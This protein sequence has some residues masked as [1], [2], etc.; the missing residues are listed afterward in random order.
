MR[1]DPLFQPVMSEVRSTRTVSLSFNDQTLEVPAG[2]SVAAA[3]LMSGI[4]RF[5]ATPVSESP[6][7]P[8][9][10]MGVCFECLVDIDGVP[11]RQSCL[12]E[13]ADGM[14]IRSQEGARDL[15]FQPGDVQNADVQ[16]AS[17][18]TVEVQS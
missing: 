5:R 4:N 7:A 8:Y 10:M 15:I 13:V 18:Q 11:N 6:R 9:C 17:V 14:R 16:T 1:T 2:I 3:L 12:I